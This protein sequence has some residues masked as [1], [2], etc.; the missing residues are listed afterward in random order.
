MRLYFGNTFLKWLSVAQGFRKSNSLGDFLLGRVP[1]LHGNSAHITI[2]QMTLLCALCVKQCF[3]RRLF[4][5]NS[6][7]YESFRT[8]RTDIHIIK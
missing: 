7:R 6:K 3:F 5:K 1:K 2:F 8:I 4:H